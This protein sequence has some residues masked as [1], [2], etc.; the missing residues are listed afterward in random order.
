MEKLAEYVSDIKRLILKI[1]PTSDERTKKSIT[2]SYFLKWLEDKQISVAAGMKD[3]HTIEVAHQALE[4]YW[5]LQDEIDNKTHIAMRNHP[6]GKNKTTIAEL[7][8]RT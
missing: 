7:M 5:S 8:L 2:P 6:S 1:F 4:T 3:P